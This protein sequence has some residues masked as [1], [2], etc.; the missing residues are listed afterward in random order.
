[1]KQEILKS[2]DYSRMKLMLAALVL[3][4]SFGLSGCSNRDE[5]AQN[6]SPSPA[7]HGQHQ[8]ASPAATTATEQPTPRV[9]HFFASA[10]AAKPYP[11]TLPPEQFSDPGAYHAYRVA[12]KI[13]DVLA[14]QPCYCYCD[15]GFGHKSLLDCHADTH[16]AECLVCMKETLLAE[17]L[18]KEGKSA[19]DIREA[20]ERGEWKEVEMPA[21]R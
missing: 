13:P 9:P 4:V 1:M 16:S 18:N 17:K 2:D 8:A 6:A 12:Q 15:Q 11:K 7:A 14:Q 19:A 5:V 10:E 21:T 3:V 20:I